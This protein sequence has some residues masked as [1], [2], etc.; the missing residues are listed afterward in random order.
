MQNHDVLQKCRNFAAVRE[1]QMPLGPF[2]QV[3]TDNKHVKF[4]LKIPS[5]CSE[6]GK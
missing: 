6:N 1:Y 2:I 3:W 5:G 4:Q